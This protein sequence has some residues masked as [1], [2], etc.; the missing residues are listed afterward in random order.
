[1]DT[2]TWLNDVAARGKLHDASHALDAI[3]EITAMRDALRLI[4]KN[5]DEYASFSGTQC[6]DI[7][8]AAL[9]P[10]PADHA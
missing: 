3:A 4:A 9:D 6:R 1:M 8:L 2:L 7:A 5:Y 10:E